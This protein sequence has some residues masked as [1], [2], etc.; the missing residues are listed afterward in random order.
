MPARPHT[1]IREADPS[2]SRTPHCAH[3]RAAARAGTKLVLAATRP[4]VL[5]LQPPPPSLQLPLQ[6]IVLC[7]LLA[8]MRQSCRSPAFATSPW[9]VDLLFTTALGCNA[10]RQNKTDET[11]ECNAQSRDVSCARKRAPRAGRHFCVARQLF[12]RKRSPGPPLR[13]SDVTDAPLGSGGLT[14]NCPEIIRNDCRI[15][16]GRIYNNGLSARVYDTHM[17]ITSM[18]LEPDMLH[19]LPV[20]CTR[21]VPLEGTA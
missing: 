16:Y 8:A 14:H 20:I 5:V 13:G 10:A 12:L 15:Y 17:F 3:P 6:R 2:H 1:A 4:L 11:G 18:S 21:P 19:M 9:R 7:P